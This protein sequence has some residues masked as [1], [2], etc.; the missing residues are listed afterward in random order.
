RCHGRAWKLRLPWGW[1]LGEPGPLEGTQDGN[2]DWPAAQDLHNT[3]VEPICRKYLNLRYQLLPYLYS[4]VEQAHRVG[5]PLMRAL[6][7]TWPDDP[8]ASLVDDS[9]LWGDSILVAPVLE[10]AAKQRKTY[11]PAEVWWDYW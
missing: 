9:Y 11:L 3:E 7:I 8:K 6:W 10:K 1:N 4:S 5:L 2:P